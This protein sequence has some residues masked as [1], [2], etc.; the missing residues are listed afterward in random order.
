MYKPYLE[1]KKKKNQAYL[2]MN[3]K[4]AGF[5][6]TWTHWIFF[7]IRDKVSHKSRYLTKR[8][9]GI[10]IVGHVYIRCVNDAS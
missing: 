8:C 7:Y 5:G 2:V 1:K 4:H 10:F 6:R 3:C 9:L